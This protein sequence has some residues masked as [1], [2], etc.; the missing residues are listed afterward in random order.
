MSTRKL[1]SIQ[2]VVGV[3]PIDGADAIERVD[4]LGWQ[5]VARK[6]EFKTADLVCYCEIDSLLPNAPWSQFLWKKGDDGKPTYRLRTVKLRG[7]VSQGLVL[8]LSVLEGK[9]FPTDT[10]ENPVYPITEGMD[11]TGMLGITKYDPPIPAQLAGK[12]K[13]QFPSFIPKTDEIRVQ[14]EPGIIDEF[15]GLSV[16]ITTKMDGSSG[17][18][19]VYNGEFGV[20]SRSLDLIEDDANTFWEVA[21]MYDLKAKLLAMGKNIAIQGEVCGEGI[22]KNRLGLKG[23]DLF[24]F[25][26]YDIQAARYLDVDHASDVFASL[27]VKVV[28]T[29]YCGVF[30]PTWDVAKLIEMAKGTYE[31]SGKYREGIVIRPM[32]EQRSEVL[33]GRM[34]FKVINQDFLLENEDA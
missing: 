15:K 5:C 3:H 6:G 26:V 18:F 13:G 34:S 16:H 30:M 8:P 32:T 29:I 31:L 14:A 24:C 2:K 21:R 12:V 27:G 1:A 17:T 4:I 19:Y 7:Q 28:P 22:Q 25:N 33:K 20:C 11:V 9:K 23:H 10:R